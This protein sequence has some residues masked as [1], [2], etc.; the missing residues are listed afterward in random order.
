MHPH[1][2]LIE[3]FYTSFKNSDP[4]G[5]IACYHPDIEFSDPVFPG[6]RG[7]RAKA[8]WAM[9]GQNKADPNNRWFERVEADDRTGRAH[10]EAKYNF[11]LNGRPVHNKIDAAFEFQD[12]K[13]RK[14][15]DTF[16]FYVW[17]K[18]AFG[19]PAV[20]LGW[21]PFFQKKVQ[22]SLSQRL[23]QFIEGHPEFK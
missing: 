4:A 3:T 20:L 7:N 12:G 11:P 22:T 18:Q 23:D 5:M 9:L 19:A 17:S 6:L 16:D 13:I 1:A 21:T 10:W 15:T 8:M 2:Q 14:H